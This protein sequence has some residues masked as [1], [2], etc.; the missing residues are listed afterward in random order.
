MSH[1]TKA[2]RCATVAA[3]R[4]VSVETELQEALSNKSTVMIGDSR[5]NQLLRYIMGLLNPEHRTDKIFHRCDKSM[6]VLDPKR[7]I[8]I[9][10]PLHSEYSELPFGWPNSKY[11]HTEQMGEFHAGIVEQI[12]KE[13]HIPLWTT[14]FATAKQHPEMYHD[15]VHPGK[16]LL[17]AVSGLL[18]I[19]VHVTFS[20]IN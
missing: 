11:N 20:A 6:E 12:A 17:R 19:R 10:I 8:T 15:R 9:V 14:A 4:A 16:G 7:N 18:L 5:S 1:L 13:H 3:I 2:D